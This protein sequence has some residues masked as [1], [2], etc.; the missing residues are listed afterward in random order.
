MITWV[1]VARFMY[2]NVFGEVVDRVVLFNNFGDA[3]R[4]SDYLMQYASY[5]E[6]TAN[7]K[8]VNLSNDDIGELNDA[9]KR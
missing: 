3:K 9:I 2:A 1:V 6:F 4:Y 7:F 8:W 5:G